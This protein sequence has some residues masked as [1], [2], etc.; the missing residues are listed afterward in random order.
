MNTTPMAG[1]ARSALLVSLT[2]RQYSGRKKDSTTQA[3]VIAAKQSGSSRAATVYKSLFADCTELEA[4]TKFSANVRK[5]HYERTLPWRDGGARLLPVTALLDYQTEIAEARTQFEVLVQAFLDKYDTLVAAAAFRL[6]TLFDRAEYPLRD[7]ILRQ[8]AFE[9][10]YSPLPTSGDFRVDVENTVQ[11]KLQQQYDERMQEQVA[12]A[13][14]DAWLRTYEVLRR[15]QDRLQLEDDGSRR[16]FRETMIT[17]AKELCDS[18][19]HLNITKDPDLEAA[20]AQLAGI[21]SDL[22]PVELRKEESVRLQTLTGVNKILDAFDWGSLG[23]AD[24]I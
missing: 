4:I 13:Q 6:G 10:D 24:E 1:I 15:F 5:R 18:L 20:R 16:T 14:R 12:Q 23:D 2:I 8:F 3:E 7:K 9:V 21:V 11:A 22:N 17:N 19:T